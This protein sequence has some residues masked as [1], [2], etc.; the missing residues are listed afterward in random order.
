MEQIIMA[1]KPVAEKIRKELQERFAGKDLT[2]ATFLIGDNPAAQVY[3]R[4]LLRTAA[5]LGI[6]TRDVVLP[7]E[8]SQAEAEKVLRGLSDDP[9]VSGILPLVPF[10]QHIRRMDLVQQMDPEKD[11]GCIHPINGGEC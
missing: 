1:G 10:P 9:Q 11:M 2:L 7:K 3:K 8:T 4:S 6:Q 5:S